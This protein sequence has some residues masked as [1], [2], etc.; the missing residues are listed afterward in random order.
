ML[1]VINVL[2]VA[3]VVIGAFAVSSSGARTKDTRAAD[4]AA[5][6]SPKITQTPNTQQT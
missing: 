4:E 2:V 3:L 5:T 1:I 6:A